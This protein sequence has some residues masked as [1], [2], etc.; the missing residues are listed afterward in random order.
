MLLVPW[1]WINSLSAVSYPMSVSFEIRVLDRNVPCVMLVVPWNEFTDILEI[2]CLEMHIKRSC[3]QCYF[4]TKHVVRNILTTVIVVYKAKLILLQ[5]LMTCGNQ[6]PVVEPCPKEGT[7]SS[8]E[9][10]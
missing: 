1:K 9:H 7:S 10:V 2:N 4:H 8:G 5:G 6:N 3:S